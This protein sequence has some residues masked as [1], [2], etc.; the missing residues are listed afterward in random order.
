[1]IRIAD[2]LDRDCSRPVEEFI[3]LDND[4]PDNVSAE[5]TEYIATDHIKAEYERLF[6]AMAAAPKSPG[7]DVGVWISG[8]SPALANLPSRKTSDTFWRTVN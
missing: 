8:F 2:L 5:L 3:K 4:D 7:E 6:S 1:M